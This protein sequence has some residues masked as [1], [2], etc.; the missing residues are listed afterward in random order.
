ML[1]YCLEQASQQINSPRTTHLD[2]RDT[3]K[4]TN[5]QELQHWI[6]G[7]GNIIIY[8]PFISVSVPIGSG[9]S[10]KLDRHWCGRTNWLSLGS[11]QTLKLELVLHSNETLSKTGI[12]F[13]WCCWRKI[14][15]RTSQF[16]N[17][18]RKSTTRSAFNSFLSRKEDAPPGIFGD[19]IWIRDAFLDISGSEHRATAFLRWH[20]SWGKGRKRTRYGSCR[21][22]WTRI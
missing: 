21:S 9:N 8:T 20:K 5:D 14:A 2:S 3:R 15:N 12:H 16:Q 4:L 22:P 13:V 1:V 18:F 7:T 6:T 19:K 11:N 17:R 10:E